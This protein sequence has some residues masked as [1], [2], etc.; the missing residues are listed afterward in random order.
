M[1]KESEEKRIQEKEDKAAELEKMESINNKLK[2]AVIKNDDHQFRDLVPL[3]DSKST[4]KKKRSKIKRR[5]RTFKRRP[6]T[7]E[8][9]EE[10]KEGM[11]AI[12][13]EISSSDSECSSEESSV[14]SSLPD[15]QER[16][17]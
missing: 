8:M 12:S 11:Q 5:T 6:K 9:I 3:D 14:L 13:A 4:K 16:R 1:T 7:V 17:E 2:R 15:I 10:S